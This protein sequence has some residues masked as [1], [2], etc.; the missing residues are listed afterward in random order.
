MY[1]EVLSLLA[2]APVFICPALVPTAI[3]DIM[4]S[5]VSPA[6][7]AAAGCSAGYAAASRTAGYT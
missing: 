1:F 3:S 5:L 2:G 7:Y 4:S 6:S